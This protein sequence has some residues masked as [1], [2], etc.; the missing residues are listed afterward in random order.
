MG[1]LA[2][3]YSDSMFPGA[4]IIVKPTR[5]EALSAVCVG[6][7]DVVLVETR[8]AQG[9][10]LE[11][12]PG[13]ESKIFYPMGVEAPT[14]ELGIGSTIEATGVANRLWEEIDAMVE[15]G[16]MGRLMRNWSFYC[17]G[18]S[19]LIYESQKLKASLAYRAD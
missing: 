8:P 19:E 16:T 13:C 11:R 10:V 5:E 6:E 1:T 2:G 3:F 14:T 17:S 7:A 12:P 15:D 18:E 9:I 4:E